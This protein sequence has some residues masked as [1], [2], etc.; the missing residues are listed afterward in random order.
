MRRLMI[1]FSEAQGVMPRPSMDNQRACG[2]LIHQVSGP[3]ARMS[4]R[5]APL[6]ARRITMPMMIAI[7]KSRMMSGIFHHISLRNCVPQFQ[8]LGSLLG[9]ICRQCGHGRRG[10]VVSR[11]QVSQNVWVAGCRQYGQAR[12]G[13]WGG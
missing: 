5:R 9:T 2:P 4:L 6:Q 8:H 3:F 11:P 12:A 13:I 1:A 7:T 10:A